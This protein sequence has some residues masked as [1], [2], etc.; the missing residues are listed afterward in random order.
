M[1]VVE[2]V[3]PRLK[4]DGFGFDCEF[5][6]AC[7][8]LGIPVVEVPVRVHYRDAA[9]TT[10]KRA[11]LGMVRDLFRIRR[12]WHDVLPEP[13]PDQVFDLQPQAA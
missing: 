4:C 3:I 13:F 9:S 6:T 12:D 1:R 2:R 10:S 11:M 5:L 7:S 8:R